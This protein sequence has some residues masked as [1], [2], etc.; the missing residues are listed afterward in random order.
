MSSNL[1]RTDLQQQL[2]QHGRET[3]FPPLTYNFSANLWLC[4]INMHNTIFKTLWS[5]SLRICYWSL[6]VPR[7]CPTPGN[8][9][10][11]LLPSFGPDSTGSVQCRCRPQRRG[12]PPGFASV[13]LQA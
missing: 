7:P 4:F 8:S 12:G 13:S 6:H 3:Q 2:P 5:H 1:E 9:Q 10:S 11:L